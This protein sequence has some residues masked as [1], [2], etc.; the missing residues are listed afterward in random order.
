MS[1]KWQ[2]ARWRKSTISDSGA[3]VEVASVDGIV[4][5]RDTKAN[6]TGPVLEFNRKEWE[7]FLGGIDNGEFTMEALSK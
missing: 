2:K 5:V 7:A 1:D 4:G 6:G 3:C